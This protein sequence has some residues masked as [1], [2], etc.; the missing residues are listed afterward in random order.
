L[1]FETY[2][3]R[4]TSF[5]GQPGSRPSLRTAFNDNALVESLRSEFFGGF[6]GASTGAAN[7]IDRLVCP[8]FAGF[9]KSFRLER[10]ERLILRSRRMHFRKLRRSANVHH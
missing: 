7:E 9:K 2:R 5:Q 6:C 1:A 10:I 4:G 8:Q 3:L